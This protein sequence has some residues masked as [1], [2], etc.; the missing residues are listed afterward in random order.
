MVLKEDLQFGRLAW[1]RGNS[2]DFLLERDIE[3]KAVT[4]PNQ[5]FGFGSPAV[6]PYAML[7]KE[8]AHVTDRESVLEEILRLFGGF[9]IGND[10]FLDHKD[11]LTTRA[12][13]GQE[14]GPAIFAI[15]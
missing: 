14:D 11:Q 1:P 2:C 13:P 7:A 15:L 10:N 9:R 4:G 6:Q 5:I 8:L 12:W 3:L